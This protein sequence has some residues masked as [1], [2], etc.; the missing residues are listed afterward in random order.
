MF[1]V[2]K[3]KNFDIV[4]FF[5]YD[6]FLFFVFDNIISFF[7]DDIIPVYAMHDTIPK[8]HFRHYYSH[9]QMFL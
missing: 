8:W 5:S 7:S 1:K 9:P 4:L 3:Y 2:E 6:I